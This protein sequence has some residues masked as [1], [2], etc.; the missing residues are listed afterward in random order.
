MSGEV[1]SYAKKMD[2]ENAAKSVIG[3]KAVIENIEVKFSIRGKKKDT[4]IAID[5]LTALKANHSIP[6][7][8]ITIII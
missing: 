6:Q 1:Y 3:V 7:N 2:A 8:K 4:D 5:A